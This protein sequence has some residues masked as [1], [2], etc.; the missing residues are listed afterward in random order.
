MYT[1]LSAPGFKLHFKDQHLKINLVQL[2][3]HR[4]SRK[5]ATI[6]AIATFNGSA[7]D[8]SDS[9]SFVHLSIFH[10][11]LFSNFHSLFVQNIDYSLSKL[12][13][14]MPNNKLAIITVTFCCIFSL[15]FIQQLILNQKVVQPSMYDLLPPNL[16]RLLNNSAENS[17][18]TCQCTN[19]TEFVTCPPPIEAPST[20]LPTITNAPK[21]L[22]NLSFSE[23]KLWYEE[24]LTKNTAN[25]PLSKYDI[26]TTKKILSWTY[27]WGGLPKYCIIILKKIRVLS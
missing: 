14:M 15:V 1:P 13:E 25:L 27:A 5:L 8:L 7:G 3:P 23:H 11:V 24:K 22:N 19:N 6:K 10:A 9:P 18:S 26:R 20:P 17:A 21:L 12:S 2:P 16:L 4:T